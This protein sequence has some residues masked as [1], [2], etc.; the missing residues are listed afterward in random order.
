[1]T[2]IIRINREIYTKLIIEKGIPAIKI[3][4]PRHQKSMEIK[5]EYENARPHAK[6]DDP[7]TVKTGDMNGW[8]L[9]VQISIYLI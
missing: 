5:I 1:M 2:K 9:I 3:K 6:V 4:W 7:E 8:L